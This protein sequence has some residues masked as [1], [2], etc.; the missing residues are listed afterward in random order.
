MSEN[1]STRVTHSHTQ[2]NVASPE[3]VFPLLCPVREAEWVPEWQYR[4]IYS[5]S[6]V[7]ELGCVFATPND[8]GAE[9]IWQVTEY[10]PAAGR[11]AF[12]WVWPGMVAAQIRIA[13]TADGADATTSEIRYTYTGLSP[14]GNDEV[15]RYT[16]E[17]FGKKMNGWETAINYYLR[18]GRLITAAAWE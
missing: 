16:G 14:A 8:D 2:R 18:T 11:I 3:K 13:L 6:G 12:A 4:M 1:A 7:A 10:D 9:T 5:Q 17:W 15:A